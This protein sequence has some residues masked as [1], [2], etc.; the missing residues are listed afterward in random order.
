M[1]RT[2]QQMMFR[3]PGQRVNGI[4]QEGAET[5][6]TIVA[7]VQPSSLSDND[8]LQNML[9]GK[10]IERAVRIYTNTRLNVAGENGSNG[11]IL[12]WQ[13]TRYVVSAVGQ[14]RTTPLRHYRYIAIKELE[15]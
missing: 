4:W 2:P 12:I 11:D 1:I 7:S 9:G 5:P 13:G 14:W 8:Q 3:S 15:S 6:G 10:R